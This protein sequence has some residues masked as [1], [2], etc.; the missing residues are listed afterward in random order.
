MIG[1][2]RTCSGLA[3]S[4]VSARKPVASRTADGVGLE[5]L[6]DAEVEQLHDTLLGD[7]DIPALDVAVD[8]QVLMDVVHGRAQIAEQID[9]LVHAELPHVAI[10]IDGIAFD[11]LHDE[12][13]R[14]FL[15]RAAVEQVRDVADGSAARGSA[16]PP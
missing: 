7:E 4:G 5:Q 3:Y 13:R 8:H 10:H 14:A 15:G 11:V 1:S 9:P 16:A 6:R 12:I 2:P